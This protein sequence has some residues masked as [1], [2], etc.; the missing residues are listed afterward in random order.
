MAR[1]PQPLTGATLR[2]LSFAM[3]A[4]FSCFLVTVGLGYIAAIYLIFLVDVDPHRKMEMGLVPGVAARY[5]G[6]RAN[7][8]LESALRGAMASVVGAHD[9]A[10]VIAWLRSCAACHSAKSGLPVPPL[11]TF[12]E[13]KK[14]AQTDTGYSL[15]ELARVSH[16]LEVALA[17]PRDAVLRHLG[18]HRLVVDHEV[19]AGV[20]L[21]GSDRRG[22][23]GARARGADLDLAVGNV[24]P[25]RTTASCLN[26]QSNAL[27]GRENPQPQHHDA[28]AER[29]LYAPLVL[30]VPERDAVTHRAR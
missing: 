29:K 8:R 21:G 18:R 4:L 12:E 10:Q 9:R 20:R 16:V 7:T 30:H 14:F 3:R 26:H 23:H 11:T 17:D 15:L 28:A 6:D 13:V 19:R 2:T 22:A 5:Y 25:A 27:D 1:P 24:V